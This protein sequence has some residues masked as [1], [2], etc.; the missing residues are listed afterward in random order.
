MRAKA[1]SLA[2]EGKPEAARDW[3]MSNPTVNAKILHT[4]EEHLAYNENLG[5]KGAEDAAAT[6]KLANWISIGISLAVIVIVA[7]LGLGTTRKLVAELNEAVKVAETVASGDLSSRIDVTS[8]DEVGRLMQAL[9]NMNDSLL[10]IVAEVRTG[11]DTIATA[12]AQIAAGN[13]DLSSRTEQQASSLEETASSM[14]EMT[15]TVRQNGDNA[16]QANQLAITASEIAVKGGAVVS[17]VV[18]TMSSINESSKKMADIISVIDGI[19]FQTNILALNAAVEAAR[20]GEQGRG[21]AVV[22]TEVRSLAQRSATAAREIKGLIDDSVT[23]VGEGTK[24]VD[25]AGST[26]TEVVSSIRRSDR[27]HGRDHLS[28]AR[29]GRW[30][31]TDQPGSH[32]DGSCDTAECGAGRGSGGSGGIV[33]GSGSESGAGG[34]RVPHRIGSGRSACC[35]ETS[36]RRKISRRRQISRQVGCRE[37]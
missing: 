20:A 22:A 18:E 1:I 33:A 12:S 26:M 30:Y 16:N 11:T 29:A 23:K 10:R 3:I 17:Q 35:Q 25:Q 24:L 15:S 19:A 28:N 4:F 8:K 6:L 21:F 37:L 34:Q 5:K 36:R 31:R 32:A 13:Q 2:K 9:K 27:H 14:E 7:G